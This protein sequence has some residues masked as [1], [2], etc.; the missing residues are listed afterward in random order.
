MHVIEQLS[1]LVHITE[2]RFLHSRNLMMELAKD[3]LHTSDQKSQRTIEL[4]AFLPDP[5]YAP[6][7]NFFLEHYEKFQALGMRCCDSLQD[8][9]CQ[10]HQSCLLLSSLDN[11]ERLIQNWGCHPYGTIDNTPTIDKMLGRLCNANQLREIFTTTQDIAKL[12][13]FFLN[14]F[15]SIDFS[16]EVFQM[17]CNGVLRL[18][19]RGTVEL[20]LPFIAEKGYIPFV[21]RSSKSTSNVIFMLEHLPFTANQLQL[22]TEQ[23][24]SYGDTIVVCTNQ[25]HDCNDK[26][27]ALCEVTIAIGSSHFVA[28]PYHE[29]HQ[30]IFVSICSTTVIDIKVV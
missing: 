5:G 4:A 29:A 14:Y 25:I 3:L 21:S 11:I 20:I 7:V 19:D 6:L 30:T 9:Q 18:P 22:Y 23:Q 28:L 24:F 16:D 12:L 1:R 17:M 15:P 26:P 10:P 2:A 13:Q 8:Y 27:H